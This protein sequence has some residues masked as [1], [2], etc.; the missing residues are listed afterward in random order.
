VD[1]KL[2]IFGADAAGDGRDFSALVSS[3]ELMQDLC[4]YMDLLSGISAPQV[5]V[6]AASSESRTVKVVIHGGDKDT[7]LAIV[8]AACASITVTPRGDPLRA[9]VTKV[10]LR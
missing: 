6:V 5:S 7:S 1:I 2:D 8:R 9:T 3:T 4:R 10:V